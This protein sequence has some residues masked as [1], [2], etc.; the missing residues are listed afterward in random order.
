MGQWTLPDAM[1]KAKLI[2]LRIGAPAD[3]QHYTDPRQTYQTFLSF[4]ASFAPIHIT[5]IN[6]TVRIYQSIVP[7]S[8]F[9]DQRGL[10]LV[11]WRGQSVSWWQCCGG[12]RNL[13]MKYNTQHPSCLSLV[14]GLQLGL[15]TG[16]SNTSCS[17]LDLR[18]G[19]VRLVLSVYQNHQG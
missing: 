8:N 11:E 9:D 19:T 2:I 12:G 7:T 5:F 17:Y 18:H 4:L 3:T 1:S 6:L 10:M 15:D 14:L 16:G 13:D